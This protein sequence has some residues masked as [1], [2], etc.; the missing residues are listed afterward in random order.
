MNDRSAANATETEL[1][2]TRTF[3]APRE[4]VFK[5]FTEAEHLKYWW[6][7]KGT[8]L[9][10][11]K[12][13]LRPG[14]IMLYSMQ[15]ESGPKMWG[16]FV[17]Q[18][19]VTPEKVVFVN[20]FADENGELAPNPFQIHNWPEEIWNVWTFEEQGDR[21]ILTLRGRPLRETPEGNEAFRGMHDSMKQGFGGTFE[22]LEAYLA[23]IL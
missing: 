16:R 6:G 22:Q 18:E 4:L 13:D 10:V 21:T 8:S 19:I 1:V 3:D 11:E 23:S 2:L 17:Y 5:A 12:F 7:P 9:T 15:P 20:S 14:G